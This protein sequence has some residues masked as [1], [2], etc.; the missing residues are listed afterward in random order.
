M[1]RYSLIHFLLTLACAD[2][3]HVAL[4]QE[5]ATMLKA[6]APAV[7]TDSSAAKQLPRVLFVVK[8]YSG[9][10]NTRLKAVMDTWGKQ[11][12]PKMLVIIGDTPSTEYPQV[13]AVP[14]CT[15]HELA[16]RVGQG[17]LLAH[18]TSGWDLMFLVDDDHYVIPDKVAEHFVNFT[19]STPTAFGQCCCGAGPPF[20]YCNDLGGFCGGD[21][22]GMN[23]AAMNLFV[24]K[25]HEEFTDRF[26][27]VLA[28][29]VADNRE[30]IV[31]SCALRQHVRNLKLE[32]S[33][34]TGPN[35]CAAERAQEVLD[36]NFA[37]FH[38]MVP[39]NMRRL[40]NAIQDKRG[41]R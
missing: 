1:L 10:Y 22:Y 2:E 16:C 33:G 34:I 13:N 14:Q 17:I 7:K 31:T 12:D 15:S 36:N 26:T 37:V 11:V 40:H 38:Q 8:T 35:G 25:T 3:D 20:H 27:A 23:R 29:K 32:E 5:R 21:G 18:N 9:N 24:D 19:G 4:L 39:D 6:A 28:S 41:R 30:D